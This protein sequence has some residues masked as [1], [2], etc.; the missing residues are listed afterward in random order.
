MRLRQRLLIVLCLLSVIFGYAT[1]GYSQTE[2][3][4]TAMRMVLQEEFAK[5]P[6]PHAPATTAKILNDAALRRPGW[7]LLGKKGGNRC[8]LSDGRDISCDFIVWRQ[9]VRGWDVIGSVGSPDSSISG[10]NSGP[11]EDMTGA[12]ANGSRT[13][14]SPVGTTPPNPPVDPPPTF[15]P[16]PLLNRISALEAQNSVLQNELNI[17]KA[18]AQSLAQANQEQ[19]AGL[20]AALAR[21]FKLEQKPWPNLLCSGRTIFGLPVSCKVV[22]DVNPEP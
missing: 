5:Y 22:P 13:L 3:E 20:E 18:T 7:V 17:V 21:I 16:T 9:T 6:R 11:G 12:I 4:K 8:P 1:A 15:D 14:E 19:A 2:T 10:P